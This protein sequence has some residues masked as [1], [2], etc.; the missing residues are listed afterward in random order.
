MKT[1]RMLVAAGCA[2]V[3]LGTAPVAFAQRGGGGH[4]GGGGGG[5]GRGGGATMSR[6]GGS[7]GGS[8]ESRRGHQRHGLWPDDGAA[9]I[10]R[11]AWAVRGGRRLR[12]RRFL[13]PPRSVRF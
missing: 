5:G 3:L 13:R 12:T 7:A 11:H 8:N 10:R 4:G 2:V 1:T 6:G 9:A